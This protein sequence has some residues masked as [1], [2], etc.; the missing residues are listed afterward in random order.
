M[1]AVELES[2]RRLAI[3]PGET[4]VATL[5]RDTDP[6]TFHKVKDAI[7]GH[8]PYGVKLILMLAHVELQVIGPDASDSDEGRDDTRAA[9]GCATRAA[10]G[11]HADQHTPH[12]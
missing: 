9:I 1:T 4:L 10:S 8:L 12:L 3:K 11:D 7:A 2:I 6:Q 5:P